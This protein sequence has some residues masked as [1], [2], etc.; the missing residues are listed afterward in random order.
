MREGK[1]EAQEKGARVS[2]GASMSAISVSSDTYRGGLDISSALSFIEETVNG[3]SAQVKERVC[4]RSGA[5]SGWA[6]RTGHSAHP[7][8]THTGTR[9]V[10]S[11]GAQGYVR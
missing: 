1:A 6:A 7:S 2:E 8:L 11:H 9:E 3:I 5:I 10:G 4:G